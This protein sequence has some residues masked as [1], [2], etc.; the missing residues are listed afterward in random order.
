MR[1]HVQF[2]IFSILCLTILL[3]SCKSDDP[4]VE[5]KPPVILPI[6][7]SL[8]TY[9]A[10]GD[11]SSVE[12]L[13]Q[14]DDYAVEVR[15]TGETDYKSSF[16]YKTD[17][18]AGNLYNSERRPEKS[19]SF[20]DFSF[21]GSPVDVRVTCNFTANNV[22]IR[23]LNFKIPVVHVGNVITFTLSQPRKISVEV[24]DRNNP[25]FIFADTID[26]PNT[27][28]TYYYGP[29]IHSIG[30]S[31]QVK[32]GESVYIAGGAVIEGSF[33]FPYP[34]SNVSIK[35]R[36]ILC[37]GEWIHESADLSFLGTH[38]AIKGNS[39]SN[40]VIEG[41]TIAN[42][43]GWTIPIY[44]SD[45]LTHDNQFRNIKMVSWNG[46]TDGIWVNGKN[47]I[48]DDC[49]IF[50]NDDIFMSHSASN[51]KISNIVAW[52][53]TW[54]RF[55]WA[56]SMQGS[57]SD[58]TFENINL[59]GK[60]SGVALI[61]VDGS[62]TTPITIN[63]ISFKNMNIEEHPSTSSYNTNKFIMLSATGNKSINNWVFENVNLLTRNTDEG[64]FYG[65]SNGLINGIKFK[66]FKIGGVLMSN[67]EVAGMDRNTFAT[68]I[69]FEP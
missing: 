12:H 45:Q 20:T 31:K 25:L 5:E 55:Y 21:D 64:D 48:I 6:T 33:F 39:V 59:I 19:A 22:I 29:G 40:L 54:G 57:T 23:P 10:P 1:I 35:G 11:L 67:L 9:P 69:T 27:N 52:G 63:N 4:I 58:M 60:E 42:S 13:T 36:G 65:T 15:K 61:L 51:C 49:F 66:N 50:N 8:V 24:N 17:N 68:N 28:A 43:C 2:S 37:M 3:I 62:M 7:G 32:S 16:V 53:G 18:Y 26:V 34:T 14:S 46:N 47:H 41:I 38:S 56:G 30:L 44:N